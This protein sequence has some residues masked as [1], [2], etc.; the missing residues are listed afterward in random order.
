[1]NNLRSLTQKQAQ[2]CEDA[3]EPQCKCRCDGQLHGAKR[4]SVTGLAYGDPHSLI[5]M[6]PKCEGTGE[7]KHK[8]YTNMI[9]E[10]SRCKG[11]GFLYPKQIGTGGSDL[12]QSQ[13]DASND[14][15]EHYSNRE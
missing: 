11:K 3:K 4:G 8:S 5:K 6:C 7:Y 13:L 1:M 15:S 9:L 14:L 10:C 2:K 12:T